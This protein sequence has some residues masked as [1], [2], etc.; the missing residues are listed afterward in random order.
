MTAQP[1]KRA[2]LIV[3]SLKCPAKRLGYGLANGLNLLE[4]D[5]GAGRAVSRRDGLPEVRGPTSIPR[6]MCV[7]GRQP[8]PKRIRKNVRFLS[9]AARDRSNRR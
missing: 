9:S 1:P 2:D 4:S 8:R 5:M 3:S 6:I 7:F